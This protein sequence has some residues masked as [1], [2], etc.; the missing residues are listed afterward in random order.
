MSHNILKLNTNSFDVNSNK[1]ESITSLEYA[2]YQC[3]SVPWYT[4]S[5]Y[6]FTPSSGQNFLIY[7]GTVDNNISSGFTEVNHVTY[8][9]YIEKL[10]FSAN[11]KYRLVAIVGL[12]LSYFSGTFGA[13]FYNETTSTIISNSYYHEISSLNYCYRR[14]INTIYEHTT[15]ST[16]AD[17]VI[18]LFALNTPNISTNEVYHDCNILVEKLQ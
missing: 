13:Y 18:R 3:D 8:T 10:R 7:R 6:P 5:N 12:D 1:T 2:Y 16:P 11:G 9:S 17:I 15:S 4:T 14:R